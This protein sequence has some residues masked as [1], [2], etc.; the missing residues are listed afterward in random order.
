MLTT[1]FTVGGSSYKSSRIPGSYD[2]L[3]QAAVKI[4]LQHEGNSDSVGDPRTVYKFSYKTPAMTQAKLILNDSDL[5]HA[6][7]QAFQESEG[8]VADSAF[9]SP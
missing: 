2:E 3:K 4:V 8:S 9:K 6:I 7:N 1:I 5:M